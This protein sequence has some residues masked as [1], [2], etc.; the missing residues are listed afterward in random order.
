MIDDETQKN[1]SNG[2]LIIAASFS[3]VVVTFLASNYH[4]GVGF[5][6]NLLN[7][8]I[9]S[10]FEVTSQSLKPWFLCDASN[11]STR[12]TVTLMTKYFVMFGVV[13]AIYGVLVFMNTLPRPRVFL[14]S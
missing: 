10:E 11:I 13:A 7:Y 3:L 5:V 1:R 2:I 12:C 8:M 14:R 4:Y 6:T 9:V